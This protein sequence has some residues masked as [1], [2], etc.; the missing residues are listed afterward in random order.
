MHNISGGVFRTQVKPKKLFIDD[1]V[2]VTRNGDTLSNKALLNNGD[3]LTISLAS[4]APTSTSTYYR[5]SI[6]YTNGTTTTYIYNTSASSSL[7]TKVTVNKN[8]IRNCKVF[9]EPT[10]KIVLP[11]N[12]KLYYTQIKAATEINGIK[13]IEYNTSYTSHTSSGTYYIPKTAKDVYLESSKSYN[14]NTI[15]I[16]G[17]INK[18]ATVSTS[19]K[20]YLDITDSTNNITITS[21]LTPYCAIRFDNSYLKVVSAAK[22]EITPGTK[23]YSEDTLT[24]T[25]RGVSV[26]GYTFAG[27]RR[28]GWASLSDS[29]TVSITSSSLGDYEKFTAVYSGRELLSS[30]MTATPEYGE[31][32][33]NGINT[34]KTVSLRIMDGG[35]EQ[36]SAVIISGSYGYTELTNI[37]GS[38]SSSNKSGTTSNV[39]IRANSTTTLD[40]G[41]NDSALKVTLSCSSTIYTSQ[42]TDLDFK[43]S[44]EMI[45]GVSWTKYNS[46]TLKSAKVAKEY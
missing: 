28:E 41:Y 6:Q 23:I 7:S 18:T 24:V 31:L 26:S 15:T 30:N 44:Y 34:T 13:T 9:A 45:Y 16:S 10:I 32:G 22:G 2:T 38:S 3:E 11:S 29:R 5:K 21:T 25:S 8:S 37:G 46:F 12:V 27:I 33:L 19:S 14:D 17:D 1:T 36:V 43:F 20:V 40:S 4:K 42:W 39:L 35:S